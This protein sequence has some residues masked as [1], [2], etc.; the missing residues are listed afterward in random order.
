[1]EDG[2]YAALA[3]Y[4][5]KGVYPN[6]FSIYIDSIYLRTLSGGSY[7]LS[8]VLVKDRS[9]YSLRRAAKSYKLE[10]GKLYYVDTQQ[11]HI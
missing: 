3:D 5:K 6:G 11:N 1:M 4:L 10:A 2:Q 9:S 7:I 8:M